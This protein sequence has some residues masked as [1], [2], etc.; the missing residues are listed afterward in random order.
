M[1]PKNRKDECSG[2]DGERFASVGKVLGSFTG[3]VASEVIDI[4]SIQRRCREVL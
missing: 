4:A 2:S 1:N 3:V